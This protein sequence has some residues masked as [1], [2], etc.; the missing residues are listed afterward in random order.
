MISKNDFYIRN[1]DVIDL[2]SD[3][4]VI[5]D[6]LQITFNDNGK[7]YVWYDKER[8]GDYCEVFGARLDNAEININNIEFKEEK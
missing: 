6:I 5:S 7:E 2:Y 8:D 1:G 3:K 4:Y